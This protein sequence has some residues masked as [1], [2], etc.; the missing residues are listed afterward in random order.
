MITWASAGSSSTIRMRFWDMASQR[1]QTETR[2]RADVQDAVEREGAAVVGD[3]PSHDGQAEP[4][5]PG[6]GVATAH[7]P[8][9]HDLD[10]VG[11]NADAAVADIDPHPR[12]LGAGRDANP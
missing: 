2:G 3:N 6:L 4:V 10:F 1:F 11:R 12:L 5:A 7:E 8:A 9:L